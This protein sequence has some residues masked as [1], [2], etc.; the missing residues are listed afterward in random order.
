VTITFANGQRIT[1][2]WGGKTTQTQSPY[3]VTPETWNNVLAPNA[4]TAVGL[5]ASWS[6]TNAAPTVSCARTP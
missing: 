5:I 3:T 4:S 6:G 2:I 1:Q